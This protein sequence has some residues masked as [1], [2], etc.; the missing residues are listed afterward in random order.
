ML[1]NA[2][3]H[4]PPGGC[5]TV[6]CGTSAA[7]QAWLSVEDEG[8]GIPEAERDKVLERFYRAPGALPGGSGLGLA[9]VREVAQRHQAELSLGPGREGRGLRVQMRFPN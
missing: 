2:I 6:A 7:G 9:I 8:P 1:H 5:V 3:R 4:S